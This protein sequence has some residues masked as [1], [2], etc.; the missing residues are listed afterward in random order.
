MRAVSESQRLLIAFSSE[1]Y[2]R[3][4]ECRMRQVIY[5][6]GSIARKFMQIKQE[7]SS[8]ESSRFFRL[9]TRIHIY[10]RNVP[11]FT[12]SILMKGSLINLHFFFISKLQIEIVLQK[13]SLEMNERKR[14]YYL[15]VSPKLRLLKSF[16]SPISYSIAEPIILSSS[17]ILPSRIQLRVY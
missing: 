1:S 8:R 17:T 11:R 7:L 9:N 10:I 4:D 16:T 5:S 12:I 13:S 14:L 3:I 15:S 2:T 6:I